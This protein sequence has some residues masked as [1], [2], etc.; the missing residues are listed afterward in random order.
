MN[1]NKKTL[2]DSGVLSAGALVGSFASKVAASKLDTTLKKPL[3]RHG[4]LAA[5]GLALVAFSNPKDVPGKLMQGAG[6]GMA[7]T[8]LSEV[9]KEII[10]QGGKKPMEDGIL[11]TG[12][13]APETSYVY[14]DS[15]PEYYPYENVPEEKQPTAFLSAPEMFSEV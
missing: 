10:T 5:L 11:K 6:A 7:A 15:T 8:Q 14:V 1:I 4:A 9:I 12:L 3:L 13:S 2:T